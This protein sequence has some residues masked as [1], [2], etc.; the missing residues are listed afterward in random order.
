MILYVSVSYNRYWPSRCCLRVDV[1][2]HDRL[3]LSRCSAIGSYET[4]RA[5]APFGA[6]LPL[7]TAR[8]P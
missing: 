5:S 2:H 8:A 6:K 3:C 7:R 1:K 4:R